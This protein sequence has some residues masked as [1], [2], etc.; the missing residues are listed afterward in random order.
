MSNIFY[1]EF[2]HPKHGLQTNDKTNL[3]ELLQ[4]A[5]YMVAFHDI[6]SI[7]FFEGQEKKPIFPTIPKW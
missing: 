6:H 2:Y 4:W 1:V 3:D 5:S 7:R